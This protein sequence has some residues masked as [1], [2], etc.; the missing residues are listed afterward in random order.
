MAADSSL[1]RL[2]ARTRLALPYTPGKGEADA[3]TPKAAYGADH[4]LGDH[5]L[6]GAN[7]PG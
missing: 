2:R 6:G 1:D 5:H 7:G 3:A 4:H